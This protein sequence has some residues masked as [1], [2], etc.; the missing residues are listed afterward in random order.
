MKFQ[1]VSVAVV[2]LA[3][4]TASAQQALQW[5]VEDGGN[6]HWYMLQSGIP[7][8][9]GGRDRA[10]QVGADLCSIET[11]AERGW[12]ASVMPCVNAFVGGQQ[13]AGATDPSAG[14]RWLTGGPV[15]LPLVCD[16][17]PCGFNT[18]EEDGQQ[19]FLHVTACWSIFGDVHEVDVNGCGPADWN[20]SLIE[21]SADCNNDGIVD[22]GQILNGQLLDTN[23]DGVPD[24]CEVDPCPADV[25]GNGVVNGVDLAAV[26]CAWETD[27]ESEGGADVNGDGTVNGQDLAFVLS[28]WGPCVNVPTWATLIEFAPDPA[29]VTNPTL[30]TAISATGLPWRVR[31]TA[32]QIEFVLIPP[33]T[34][35]MG[36]SQGLQSACFD[37]EN[38][39][40]SVTLTQPFYMGRYEVTQA[41]WT[42]QMG[43][44]PSGF[45][46]ASA[47]VPLS[48][49]P[50]RPVEQ[51]SWNTIQ[52]FLSG[53]GMRLPTEA[54]WE[55]AY[56]AGTATAFHSMP[57][58]PDGTN[59]DSFAGNI[60]W[61]GFN[62]GGQ[63]RP[64]GGRAGNGFGLHDMA[65]N[66]FEWVNDWWDLYPSDAQV[67]PAGPA[68][69]TYRT[70]RGGSWSVGSDGIRASVRSDSPVGVDD[71]LGFRVARNP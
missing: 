9:Q 46:S 40:H 13:D 12:L 52:G 50:D 51:V 27:G 33:G 62:A 56:R 48:Q 37:W 29:V 3:T 39:V 47:E 7:G 16:D 10:L 8:W 49:V 61:F 23:G 4:S 66:V 25:N 5:P 6:G 67:D 69:G 24:V 68:S 45:Q 26:L 43:S 59:D 38:P 54:E 64:V 34:F 60:A 22:Y 65:G 1:C 41:Q 70:I 44:N 2:V 15:T 21:W 11:E 63:T 53:A 35:Q 36:C 42:A 28:A 71:K 57:D 18:P 19:D 31:D 20:L 58:Y 17:N 14:W 55:W 32:T 30:R